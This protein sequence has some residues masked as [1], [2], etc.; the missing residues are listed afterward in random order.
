MNM[1]GPSHVQERI[2]HAILQRGMRGTFDR[3]PPADKARCRMIVELPHHR[4]GLAHF[5]RAPSRPRVCDCRILSA[6]H[7]VLC[8]VEVIFQCNTSMRCFQ[9]FVHPF[10]TCTGNFLAFI[11][12][13]AIIEKETCS[14]VCVCLCLLPFTALAMNK[15]SSSSSSSCFFL[16]LPPPLF[17]GYP[18]RRCLEDKHFLF[19]HNLTCSCPP[20]P[21]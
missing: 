6:R 2:T 7:A 8:A 1:V 14:C 10:Y 18:R 21:Y 4:G 17:A 16:L 5:S 9:D 12:F 11:V 19:S 15:L 13:M 3:K 20:L